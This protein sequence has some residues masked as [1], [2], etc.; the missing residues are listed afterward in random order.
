MSSGKNHLTISIVLYKNN[1]I[2]IRKLMHSLLGCGLCPE[3][4]FV[5]NSP[6]NE[7][8]SYIHSNFHYQWAG[9][10]IGFGR[11]HNII[12]D[13]VMNYGGYHIVMNADVFFD[14]G[15]IEKI[16]E[17]MNQ[18]DRIGLL[19][20]RILNPDGT[21]QPLF[22]LLPH[23]QDLFTRRFIP[24]LFKK[25]LGHNNQKYSMSFADDKSTFDAPYLSGCF[26]FLR[27][28]TLREVGGFDPR[29]FLYCEDIDLS[30]RIRMTWRTTYYADASIYHYFYKGSYKE[31]RLLCLHI[32]SAV[33]YFNKHGWFIDSDRE[34]INKE[35]LEGF[36][37]KRKVNVLP[38][39]K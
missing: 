1:L 24:S 16:V 20:P 22:K 8:E 23:P 10:N 11:A 17:Y 19:L 27:K 6:T 2:H 33:K 15:V 31:L 30:R 21:P 35:T 29:F 13:K 25:I 37:S 4:Y 5:D 26:M 38:I 7:L 32:I 14:K 36:T 18:H 34:R 28:E 9:E 3:V 12:I 39:A